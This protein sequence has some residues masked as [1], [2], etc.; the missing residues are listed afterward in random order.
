MYFYLNKSWYFSKL[1]PLTMADGDAIYH[2]DIVT[3]VILSPE[4]WREDQFGLCHIFSTI[5]LS[6]RRPYFENSIPNNSKTIRVRRRR[7]LDTFV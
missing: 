6:L 5:G 4:L 1:V 7:P 2:E 3:N